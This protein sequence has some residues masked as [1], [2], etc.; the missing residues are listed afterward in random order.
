MSVSSACYPERFPLGILSRFG[1]VS[2]QK[3]AV[4][5]M[6]VGEPSEVR[7]SSPDRLSKL[8]PGFGTARSEGYGDIDDAGT[9]LRRNT[10]IIRSPHLYLLDVGYINTAFLQFGLKGGPVVRTKP[11]GHALNL[12]RYRGGAIRPTT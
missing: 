1:D 7:R 3:R 2:G 11:V 9:A 6:A 8:T 12:L 10:R 5:A 4:Q